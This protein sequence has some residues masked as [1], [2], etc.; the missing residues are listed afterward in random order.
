MKEFIM[1]FGVGALLFAGL[2]VGRE[3]FNKTLHEILGT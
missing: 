1:W 3:Y 2:L